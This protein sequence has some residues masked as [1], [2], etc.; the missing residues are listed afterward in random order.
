MLGSGGRVVGA[1]AV[2][3]AVDLRGAGLSGVGG[4]GDGRA[5]YA[6]RARCGC[7]HGVLR[8]QGEQLFGVARQV[9]FCEAG[10]EGPERHRLIDLE[11]V[12]GQQQGGYQRVEFGL[13]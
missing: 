3:V 2:C 1:G 12:G 4:A 13:A 5:P 9:V 10:D 11:G 7:G 6:V 8:Q